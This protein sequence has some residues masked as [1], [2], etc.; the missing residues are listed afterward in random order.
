MAAPDR[1]RAHIAMQEADDTGTPLHSFRGLL[2]Q[3]ATL[4]R[5]TITLGRTSFDKITTPTSTQQ[6]AFELINASIPL[7]LK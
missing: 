4:T 5:N 6:R 1:F 3:M 2:E 7:T